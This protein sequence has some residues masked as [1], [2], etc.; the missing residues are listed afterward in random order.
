MSHTLPILSG[1]L[2]TW[3]RTVR[4]TSMDEKVGK[5]QLWT[6]AADSACGQV[7]SIAIPAPRRKVTLPGNGALGRNLGA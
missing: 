5:Q 4:R 7:W 3:L 6:G 2:P 1:L